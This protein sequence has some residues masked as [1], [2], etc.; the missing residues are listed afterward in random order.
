MSFSF[1]AEENAFKFD[2][3]TIGVS[4]EAQGSVGVK[5]VAAVGVI[6]G[7]KGD[8]GS[9]GSLPDFLLSVQRILS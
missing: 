4:A 6:S 8:T 3:L 2:V 9:I 5:P 1:D 7:P